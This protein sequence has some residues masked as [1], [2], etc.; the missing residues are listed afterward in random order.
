MKQGRKRYTYFK[1]HRD[2]P[3]ID[4]RQLSSAIWKSMLSLYGEIIVS[5]TRFFLNEYDIERG[6]GYFQCNANLLQEVVSAAVLIG[7]I[8][9]TYVSLEPLKTSGTIKA[10]LKKVQ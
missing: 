4:E 8:E 6:T 3:T 2:G 1:L 10:L 5:E 7:S 9:K